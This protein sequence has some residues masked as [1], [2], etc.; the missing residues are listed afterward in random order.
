MR[1]LVDI[2]LLDKKTTF[3]HYTDRENIENI[4]QIGLLPKI[5]QNSKNIELSKKVFLLKDLIIHYF[6]W[7]HGLNG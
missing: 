5:G 4:F 6:L 1:N 2:K 7:I 3:L